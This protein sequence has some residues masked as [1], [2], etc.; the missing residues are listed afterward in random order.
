MPGLEQYRTGYNNQQDVQY[1]NYTNRSKTYASRHSNSSPYVSL[2]RSKQV[3]CEVYTNTGW[4][5]VS[6]ACSVFILHSV[7][8]NVLRT[9]SMR[10][11]R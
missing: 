11:D 7:Y 6:T 2:I 8:S 3:G 10:M 5:S 4:C 9:G 1:K